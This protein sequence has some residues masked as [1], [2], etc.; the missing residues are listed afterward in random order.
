MLATG[1]ANPRI[2][3]AGPRI[4]A[5]GRVVEHRVGQFVNWMTLFGLGLIAGGLVLLA[6][7]YASANRHR[8][9][10]ASEAAKRWRTAAQLDH[11]APVYPDIRRSV[12]LADTVRL[13]ELKADQT[14]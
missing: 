9:R 5:A 1:Q 7:A 14:R 4:A 8:A 11:R 6:F 13:A 2:A 10:S 3:A 12:L